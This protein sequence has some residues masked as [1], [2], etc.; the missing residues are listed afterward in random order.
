MSRAV[1]KLALEALITAEAGLADI[2]DADREP[3][4]D[5]AWC[6]ER[7]AQAL[8]IPRQ[9]ITALR[10]ALAQ[11]AHAPAYSELDRIAS[12]LQSLCD[13]QAMRLGALES[14]QEHPEQMARLGW[15]C[16]ECP[17]CGSEGARAFPKPE[18]QLCCDKQEPVAKVVSSGEYGFP[19]LQWVS[20]NHSL[21]TEIGSLLYTSP[22]RRQPLTNEEKL[23]L[24]KKHFNAVCVPD[25]F[26]ALLI[27]IEAKLKEKNT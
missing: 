3:T 27:A 11:P 12:D 10:E 25:W 20:A 13:Q 9:A 5:L 1:M 4:D 2:G 24:L 26:D 15:Q 8:A 18:E 14:Q 23:D 6:E 17:A 7:A 19:V 16:F 21:D 22:P